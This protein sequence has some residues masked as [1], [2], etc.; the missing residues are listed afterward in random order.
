MISQLQSWFGPSARRFPLGGRHHLRLQ[1]PGLSPLVERDHVDAPFLGD[2]RH[3]LAV[4]RAHPTADIS[5]DGFAE[6]TH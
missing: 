3:A 5:L 6:R 4:G 1:S 2:R